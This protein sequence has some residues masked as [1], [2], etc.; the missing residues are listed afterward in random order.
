M[1]TI[2]GSRWNKARNRD[3]NEARYKIRQKLSSS[4]VDESLCKDKKYPT[5]TSSNDDDVNNKLVKYF[6]SVS[7]GSASSF[8]L[9]VISDDF[10]LLS[11]T[12]DSAFMSEYK[13]KTLCK[14]RFGKEY[15]DAMLLY[16]KRISHCSLIEYAALI[17]EFG[18][19]CS[20]ISGGICNNPFKTTDDDNLLR[21]IRKQ[22]VSKLAVQKLVLDLIPS[23]LAAYFIK[24]LFQM[25]MWSIAQGNELCEDIEKCPLCFET[26]MNQKPL[27]R[28]D[29]C[30]HKCCELCMWEY[31]LENINKRTEGNVVICPICLDGHENNEEEILESDTQDILVT[32]DERREKSLKMFKAIPKD[33]KELKQSSKRKV[34]SKNMIHSSWNSA[35]IPC[36]GR[37]QDVRRDKFFRYV[38]CGA[39]HHW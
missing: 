4:L 36:I 28:F 32:P 20:L 37:S 12:H 19:V 17:G 26:T 35:L 14:S 31:T 3:R 34:K 24:C 2:V 29:G 27:Y 15:A 8:S 30:G 33:V 18:V 22:K 10:N 1:S 11:S 25:K 13:I 21:G 39:L 9:K 23:S 6:N 38:E 5:N 7:N 16:K